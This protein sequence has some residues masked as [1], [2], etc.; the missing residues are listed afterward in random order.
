ME[1]I[2]FG[3]KVEKYRKAKE[4]STSL[5]KLAEDRSCLKEAFSLCNYR[6]RLVEN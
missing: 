1:N 2:D 5:A 6:G 3:K 4:L